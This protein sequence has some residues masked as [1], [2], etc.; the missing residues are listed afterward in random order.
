MRFIHVVSF[1]DMAHTTK[2]NIKP[3]IKGHLT[4]YRQFHTIRIR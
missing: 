2:W 4:I 3:T 1:T